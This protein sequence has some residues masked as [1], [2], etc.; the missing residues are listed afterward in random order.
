MADKFRL[1]NQL[2]SWSIMNLIGLDP[3]GLKSF[4]W[5]ILSIG[6]PGASITLKTGVSSNAFSAINEASSAVGEAPAGVGI[7]APLFWL[8]EG[9]RKAD[10]RIRKLVCAAGG[11]S[12]TVGMTS[13]AMDGRGSG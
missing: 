6:E 10:A 13:S 5:A 1:I 9:D 7:D 2:C 11:H 4:G 8:T 12:G 3:G